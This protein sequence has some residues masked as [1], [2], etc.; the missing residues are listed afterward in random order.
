[1]TRYITART[2]EINLGQLVLTGASEIRDTFTSEQLPLV[3]DG[4]MEGLKIVWGMAIAFTGFAT[5]ISLTTRW[6]RLN[7]ANLTG[8]A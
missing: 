3:L 2:S 8:A 6:T 5:L 7:T 4:Y 1:M